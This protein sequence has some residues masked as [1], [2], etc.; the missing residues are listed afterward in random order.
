MLLGST[1]RIDEDVLHMTECK[2]Q[3][4]LGDG[5]HYL[6]ISYVDG[7]QVLDITKIV[8]S[9]HPL[10][11]KSPVTTSSAPSSASALPPKS[12]AVRGRPIDDEFTEI[13]NCRVTEGCSL[14]TLIPDMRH[15]ARN[16]RQVDEE[17]VTR[18]IDGPRTPLIC[19]LTLKDPSTIIIVDPTKNELCHVIQLNAAAAIDIKV[20]PVEA[21][22]SDLAANSASTTNSSSSRLSISK[23]SEGYMVVSS[24]RQL[25]IFSL[26][27]LER[28]Q[29]I[30]A[31]PAAWGPAY[32]VTS[33]HQLWYEAEC[34]VLVGYDIP[35][36]QVISRTAIFG[37]SGLEYDTTLSK[38][39]SGWL[40]CGVS[41]DWHLRKNM[42]GCSLAE[43]QDALEDAGDDATIHEADGE[44]GPGCVDSDLEV[45][46]FDGRHVGTCDHQR[47]GC[48][49][50]CGAHIAI[51]DLSGASIILLCMMG[52]AGSGQNGDLLVLREVARTVPPLS[53]K[54]SLRTLTNML[55]TSTQLD[56]DMVVQINLALDPRQQMPKIAVTTLQGHCKIYEIFNTPESKSRSSL[57][58]GHD[59]RLQTTLS[60]YLG[61]FLVKESFW[62][63]IRFGRNINEVL[64]VS[65]SGFMIWI[66][67]R[68]VLSGYLDDTMRRAG[69]LGCT[70]ESNESITSTQV[71]VC[72]PR[73]HHRAK[74][75]RRPR[76]H[77]DCDK[78]EQ[79]TSSKLSQE[80]NLGCLAPCTAPE[81]IRG[82][83]INVNAG[84]GSCAP[85]STGE[86]VS[87]NALD[88]SL[89]LTY[90]ARPVTPR[91]R[92]SEIYVDAK[93]IDGDS[94]YTAPCRLPTSSTL[95]PSNQSYPPS[96]R[97]SQRRQLSVPPNLI[98]GSNAD[99]SSVSLA[100]QGGRMVGSPHLERSLRVCV[101]PL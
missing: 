15:L 76:R 100:R 3:H 32:C 65:L 60:L 91:C 73:H 101:S 55:K 52:R 49:D 39:D 95:P 57:H 12:S 8:S 67:P 69:S 89:D 44:A 24:H 54:E 88:T 19:Y 72:R 27:S 35:T 85:A 41:S 7:C 53:L 14:L 36:R 75:W 22:N 9:D 37:N 63:H 80:P 64:V 48:I 34:G 61:G 42:S 21:H 23:P 18:D 26:T 33:N 13:F 29:T 20:T 92:S 78:T 2:F 97:S 51:S 79:R 90:P 1:R 43:G 10:E 11:P 81:T 25:R 17:G 96:H 74:L 71:R 38:H 31:F 98:R 59:L 66:S 6:L 56:D 47:I 40:D 86:G 87:D 77:K 58:V 28:L 62:P 30:S 83:T 45:E 93:G 70:L 68:V 16:S 84:H 50:V 94:E 82:G 5:L 46:S 99:G 4:G